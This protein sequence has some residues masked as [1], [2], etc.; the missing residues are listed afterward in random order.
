M[1]NVKF[2]KKLFIKFI[3]LRLEVYFNFEKMRDFITWF[4]TNFKNL[5]KFS[6][7]WVFESCKRSTW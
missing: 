3:L 6:I 7:F 1:W 5:L 2:F 4:D